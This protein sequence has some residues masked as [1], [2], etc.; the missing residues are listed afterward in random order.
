ML[1]NLPEAGK[2][3]DEIAEKLIWDRVEFVRSYVISSRSL[4]E[5]SQRWI[6][7]KHKHSRL[8]LHAKTL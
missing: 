3:T 8:L 6:L 1:E 7:N 2:L 4:D 5:A